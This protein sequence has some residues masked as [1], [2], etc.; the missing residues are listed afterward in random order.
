MSSGFLKSQ[1]AGWYRF[2]LGD[3][4]CTVVSD[5]PIFDHNKVT[6]MFPNADP[7]EVLKLRRDNFL[8]AEHLIFPQNALVVNTG[9]KLVLIDTGMGSSD[10]GGP[11]CGLL[12]KNLRAAGI[13]PKDI[14]LVLLTHAHPDHCFGMV[15]D[16][17]QKNFPNAGVSLVEAEF[18][19]WTDEAKLSE[20]GVVALSVGGAR[21]NILPYADRLT[22]AVD[23]RE[24]VS[25]ITTILAPG[26]TVGHCVYMIESQGQRLAN[27]G[28]LCH[29]YIGEL[30]HP[31]WKFQYDGDPDLAVK[32]RVRMFTELAREGTPILGYHF[33]WPGYG[34]IRAEKDGYVYVPA[35]LSL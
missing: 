11:N 27:I 15:D 29:D 35:L 20:E 19:F 10:L 28:D 3:F 22:F 32:T 17:G 31:G 25:G 5:G 7:E 14:D 26:H 30:A 12:M 9:T 23:E 6:D 8:P 18:T 24:V 16:E 13:D 21:K 34:H 33:P 1:N 2:A 4:E